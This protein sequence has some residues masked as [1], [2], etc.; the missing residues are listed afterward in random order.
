MQLNKIPWVQ[1]TKYAQAYCLDPDHVAACI[2]VESGG[3]TF[4]ARFEPAFKYLFEPVK[5][6][7]MLHQSVETETTQ[8]KTSWGLMHVMGAVAREL[9]FEGYLPELTAPDSGIKYGCLKMQQLSRKYPDIYDTIAAYNAGSVRKDPATGLYTN[10]KHVDRFQT[11]LSRIR[12]G[13]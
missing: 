10:Q 5:F 8:Q 12:S 9:G 4:S 3:E 13:H 2:M 6:A 1:V 11:W 7:G